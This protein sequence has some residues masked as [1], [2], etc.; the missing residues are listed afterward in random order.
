MPRICTI[1]S[2]LKRTEIDQVLVTGTGSNRGIASQYGVS[3]AAVDR[4]KAGHLTKSLAAAASGRDSE[5][6]S[7]L[8]RIERSYERAEKLYGIAEGILEK[9]QDDHLSLKAVATACQVLEAS[10]KWTELLAQLTGELRG[11][12]AER[13]QINVVYCEQ[14]I[15]GSFVDLHSHSLP[16]AITD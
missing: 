13:V 11:Q 14:R 3:Q 15:D 4:H 12:T 7:L 6:D 9:C 1:C 2:H 10:R 5:S 16:P 8:D